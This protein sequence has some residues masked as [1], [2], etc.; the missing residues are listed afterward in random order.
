MYF[1]V[2]RRHYSTTST[3]ATLNVQLN[4]VSFL[5]RRH[6]S[7]SLVLISCCTPHKCIVKHTQ[8]SLAIIRQSLR[9][10]RT[11]L[12]SNK[13]TQNHKNLMYVN[14]WMKIIKKNFFAH[15]SFLSHFCYHRVCILTVLVCLCS[16]FIAASR[17]CSTH[18]R[19]NRFNS[20]LSAII[21]A[22]HVT[23]YH[24]WWHRGESQERQIS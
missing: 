22:T 18:I 2:S 12:D 6:P 24:S 3:S 7:H 17:R 23:C 14:W 9:H 8:L 10:D 16:L 5:Y 19:T 15:F 13:T 21:S 4:F 11:D 1:C 20:T